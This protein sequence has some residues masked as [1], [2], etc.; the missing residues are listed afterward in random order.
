MGEGAIER[1]VSYAS[2]GHKI[3]LDSGAF[4][5]RS[6]P[7]SMPWNRVLAVYARVIAAA[8]S[9]VTLILPD[10][11]GDQDGTLKVLQLFGADVL[12]MATNDHEA[13]LPLQLGE[14]EPAQ[15]VDAAIAALG[16]VPSGL[17]LPS[18]DFAF[19]ASKL[20]SLA[21]ITTALPRRLHFLGISRAAQRL[22]E[23]LL[24][25]EE[26]WPGCVVTCDAC[27][28]RAKVGQGRPVTVLR[29]EALDRLTDQAIDEWDETEDD[30]SADV[31]REAIRNQFPD[32]DENDIDAMASST[33]GSMAQ[34]QARQTLNRKQLG[35][36]ATTESIYRFA[37]D[38]GEKRQSAAAA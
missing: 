33:W 23:R 20:A 29:T 5:H 31:A 36:Q 14:R 4:I 26:V 2:E 32:L 24:R 13:L 27:E 38:E 6:D 10:V 19:P 8:T 34:L 30:V 9:S 1:V 18:R 3:L 7:Q 25:L 15:F 22:G 16:G 35:P 28:H 12:A 21:D 37:M 11:V 17:A